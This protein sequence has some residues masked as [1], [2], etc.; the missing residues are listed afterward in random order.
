MDLEI[1]GKNEHVS[2]A[3]YVNKTLWAP[4]G[5]SPW[6]SLLPGLQFENS[7]TKG[8]TLLLIPGDLTAELQITEIEIRLLIKME[9]CW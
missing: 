6:V 2:K 9:Q 5:L 8:E 7:I 3:N 1:K 4:T